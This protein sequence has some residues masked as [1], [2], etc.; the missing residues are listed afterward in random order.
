MF[1]IKVNSVTH[2]MKGRNVL[3]SNG[4]KANIKRLNE[5]NSKEGCGYVILVNNEPEKAVSL[6][7]NNFIKV[8]SFGEY[9]GI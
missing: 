7:K 1:F 8:I 5:A 4:I 3:S 9:G 6:L 2:A